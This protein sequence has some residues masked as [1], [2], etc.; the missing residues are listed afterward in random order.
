MELPEFKA[1]TSWC[2][3]LAELRKRVLYK[4]M[5]HRSSEGSALITNTE[6]EDKV[7]K[8]WN[9]LPATFCILK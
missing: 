7:I 4:R 9:T 3:K 8:A 6:V 2:G 1:I 5:K